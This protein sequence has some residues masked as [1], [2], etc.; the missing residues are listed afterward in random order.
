MSEL[1]PDLDLLRAAI[2]RLK[3]TPAVVDLVGERIYDRPPEQSSGELDVTSPYIS[4][5][6]TSSVPADSDCQ[7]GE[8]ITFQLDCWSWGGGEAYASAECRRINSAVRKALHDAELVLEENALVTLTHE[9]S[10]VLRD[11]DGITNHGV[12]VF[13]AIVEIH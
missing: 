5:G 4:L 7:A 9:Q 2:A 8:E 10:R 1:G 6:P 12:I 3:A 11:P 13:T